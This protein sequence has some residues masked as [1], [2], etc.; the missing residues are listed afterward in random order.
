MGYNLQIKPQNVTLQYSS[1]QLE[2]FGV[3]MSKEQI[4][5]KEQFSFKIK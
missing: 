4:G 2:E 5:R 3:L 1:Y